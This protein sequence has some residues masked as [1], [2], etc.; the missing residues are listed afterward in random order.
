L[1][2]PA[3]EVLMAL[4]PRLALKIKLSQFPRRQEN[5]LWHKL[6]LELLIS[7]YV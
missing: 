4:S 7:G 3:P 6:G 5:R 2:A 1:L